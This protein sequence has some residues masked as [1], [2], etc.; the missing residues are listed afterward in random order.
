MLRALWIWPALNGCVVPER[1]PDR[2]GKSLRAVDDEQQ[3]RGGIEPALDQIV[4]QRSRGRG[5]FRGALDR[6]EW[7]LLAV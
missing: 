5:V 2:L 6:P 1:R 7:M 4:D 3:R